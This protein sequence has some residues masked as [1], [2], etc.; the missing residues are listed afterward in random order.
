MKK[1]LT[2]L[3]AV[4]M[5]FS[6]AT[7]MS[8]C[9]DDT[10]AD[11]DTSS[12]TVANDDTATSDQSTVADFFP[13]SL[14][15]VTAYPIDDMSLTGWQL[16]GGMID[17]VEMEEA[18]LTALLSNANGKIEFVFTDDKNVQMVTGLNTIDGTYS[19]TSEDMIVHMVFP[20]IEY[21][22]VVTVVSETTVFMIA[23]PKQPG[24]ALYLSQ[25]DEQ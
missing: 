2:L 13:E 23:D 4:L 3:L 7:V 11:T 22:G 16:A 19:L 15:N 8:A 12:D 6:M 20:E 9:G 10:V 25:I 1:F 21:Y 5:I 18:D 17:G 24:S 14:S